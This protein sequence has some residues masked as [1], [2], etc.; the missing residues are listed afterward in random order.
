MGGNAAVVKATIGLAREMGMAVIAEGVETHR[1][2]EL[3]MAW[4]AA[5]RKASTMRSR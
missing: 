3:L 5:K 1:Q 2:A 4:G